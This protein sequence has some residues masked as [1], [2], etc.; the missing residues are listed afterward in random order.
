MWTVHFNFSRKYFG[1]LKSSF[2]GL[3]S[4]VL[5]VCEMHRVK[6]SAVEGNEIQ[7]RQ[8]RERAQ[9]IQSTI[10]KQTK[11]CPIHGIVCY[12]YEW[13]LIRWVSAN[14]FRCSL[15]ISHGHVVCTDWQNREK[16]HTRARNNETP[17]SLYTIFLFFCW[18]D[19]K[20]EFPHWLF[21]LIQINFSSKAEKTSKRRRK[22]RRRKH[23]DGNNSSLRMRYSILC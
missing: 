18:S 21:I 19:R 20:V 3:V 10:C 4:I 8:N 7:R 17:N 11:N 1:L 22:R 16:T 15:A 6:E 23:R 14:W 2:A 12:S 5:S 9:L 13:M